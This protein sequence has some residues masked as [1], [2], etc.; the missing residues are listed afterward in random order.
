MEKGIPENVSHT[1]QMLKNMKK[2]YKTYN[3]KYKNLTKKTMNIKNKLNDM[4][5]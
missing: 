3:T 1:K 2:D 4:S 5:Y